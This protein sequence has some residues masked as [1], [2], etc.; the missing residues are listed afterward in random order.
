ME[1]FEQVSSITVP[2]IETKNF[3]VSSL[4]ILKIR[5]LLNYEATLII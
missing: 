2:P 5:H 4:N 3:R 1:Y